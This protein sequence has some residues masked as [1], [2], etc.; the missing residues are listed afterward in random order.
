[1]RLPETLRRRLLTWAREYH[2]E[3]RPSDFLI[4]NE[5]GPY[6]ARWYVIRQGRRWLDRSPAIRRHDLEHENPR[7]DGGRRNVFVHQF[8]ASDDD[9]ALHDHPWPWITIILDGE[10]LE[11]V[12]AD[13]RHPGGPTVA[14]R[15][16]AGDVVM[17]YNAARPHRIEL[18]DHRPT[19]TL[20][21]TGRKRREWGFYCR[22]GWRHWRNFTA[23][24]GRGGSRGCA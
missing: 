5:N 19:T 8:L 21:L 11:H 24:D 15:R 9:R 1:M 20:F 13:A 12:P 7:V 6:L 18:I 2:S 3:A 14:H 10:Y 22:Q 4:Q 17:R 23:T 16:R